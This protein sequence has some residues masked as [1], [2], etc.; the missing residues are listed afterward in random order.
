MLSTIRLKR[1]LKAAIE[2]CEEGQQNRFCQFAHDGD[3]LLNKDEHHAC[4]MKFTDNRFRRDNAIALSF[5]KPLTHKADKV[6]QLAEE[7]CNEIFELNF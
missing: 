1:L 3:T 6:A 4:G 2:H 5:R 7:V